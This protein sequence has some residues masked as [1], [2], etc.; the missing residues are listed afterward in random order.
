[1]VLLGAA[2]VGVA[3]HGAEV[4]AP[5]G[6]IVLMGL[7][8]MFCGAACAT[9]T[10]RRRLAI[11]L[12]IPGA[13]LTFLLP[14]AWFA[15]TPGT[16]ECTVR[17]IGFGNAVVS[18]PIALGEES[19]RWVLFVAALLALGV[20]AGMLFAWRRLGRPRGEDGR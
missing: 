2:V 3:V 6:L 17:L 5:R 20:V 13:A 11:A 8:P 18:R 9:V 10:F 16:R 1:M 4:N 12:A 7:G 19:C 15:L 14:A